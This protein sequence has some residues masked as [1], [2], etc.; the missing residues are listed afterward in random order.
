MSNN[1]GSVAAVGSNRPGTNVVTFPPSAT[2]ASLVQQISPALQSAIETMLAKKEDDSST[3]H[4]KDK[5]ILHM[6]TLI[7]N[8][9]SIVSAADRCS[10][11][12]K[13]R[14]M[15]DIP[16]KKSR[17]KDFKAVG[18]SSNG[19]GLVVRSFYS[20]RIMGLQRQY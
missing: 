7:G 6:N 20:T 8:K 12:L 17:R 5:L 2:S 1:N 15:N 13:S 19:K 3:S 4:G 10:D 18:C 11:F 16:A 14:V 9:A